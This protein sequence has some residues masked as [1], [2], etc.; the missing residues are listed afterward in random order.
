MG[1]KTQCTL[2]CLFIDLKQDYSVVHSKVPE[3]KFYKVYTL[4][5][6]PKFMST[7]I[8][9]PVVGFPMYSKG[10]SEIILCKCTQI[11]NQKGD[12][13]H[14]KSKDCDERVRTV[15]EPMA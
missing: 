12:V 2:L 8:Q 13:R 10:A 15:I 9:K 7:V 1:N 5:S 14:T 11:L 6:A 4:N 3:Q